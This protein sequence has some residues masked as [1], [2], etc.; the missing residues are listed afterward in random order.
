[1]SWTPK[2]KELVALG[3]SVAAGCR[4]CTSYHL[5]AVRKTDSSEEEIRNAIERA[6]LTRRKAAVS[7]ER[8]ALGT[9]ADE[10]KEGGGGEFDRMAEL[11][12]VGA[13]YAVNCTEALDEHLRAARKGGITEEELRE[14]F[15]LAAFIKDKADHHIRKLAK[16]EEAGAESASEDPVAAASPC[17]G[18][19]DAEAQPSWAAIA[20]HMQACC[21]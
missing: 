7:M 21:C 20:K 8:Y 1:M 6:A 16:Y 13:A 14:V 2:E 10:S 12:S 5:K 3:I 18:A 9:A 17:C 11:L 15:E 19:S 4:P